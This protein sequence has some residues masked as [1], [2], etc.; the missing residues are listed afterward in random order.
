MKEKKRKEEVHAFLGKRTQFVGKLIFD[1]S[2]RIDGD[3]HR[4]IN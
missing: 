4:E 2:V 1:G 3:F